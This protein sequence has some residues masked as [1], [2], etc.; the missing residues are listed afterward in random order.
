[1]NAATHSQLY[2]IQNPAKNIE[3]NE[4]VE[5]VWYVVPF[6]KFTERGV[7]KGGNYHGICRRKV[8]KTSPGVTEGS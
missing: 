2:I 4:K 8:K 6:E 1:M 3:P 7:K 5:V